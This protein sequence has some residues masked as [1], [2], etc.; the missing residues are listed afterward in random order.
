MLINHTFSTSK[1][2]N[3]L[4]IFI[5]I[6][7][8]SIIFECLGPIL[9]VEVS[10]EIVEEAASATTQSAA[11]ATTQSAVTAIT[12]AVE[13]NEIDVDGEEEKEVSTEQVSSQQ[14]ALRTFIG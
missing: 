1:N 3:L 14:S 6:K 7:T 5:I 9:V 2:Y 8:A 4:Y 12:E 10:T 13:E 11:T